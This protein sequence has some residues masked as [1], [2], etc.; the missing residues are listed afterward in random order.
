MSYGGGYGGRYVIS[1]YGRSS[2][3]PYGIKWLL[4]VNI[5]LFVAYFFAVRT[6]LGSLFHY[7]GLIP[8]AVVSLL[9]VWQLVTYLFLHDPWD[10]WH[11]LIN[12]AM[13]WMFGKDLEST[14]GTK[15]FL[16]YYFVCGIGAAI[17]VVLMNL[18]FG[19]MSSRTIGASGAIFGV[20][21]A[22]GMMFP[23]TTVLFSLIIP[24]KAKY[25]VMIMGA[26]AFLSTLGSSGGGV[27][28]IAHL[29]GMIFGYLYLK[30]KYVKLDIFGSL[31]RQYKDWKVQRAKKKF[32]VYLKKK[33]GKGPWV[34]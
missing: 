13:L 17:C 23:D 25:F 22:F 2:M 10:F 21:L 12:M 33:G 27:S 24:M 32:Q 16:Q 11:I 18:V 15:R 20:M 26:I 31:E 14:W 7:F 8:Q 19:D 1:G 9:A 30:S 3:F 4:I 6:G 29:G 28:H 34:N 5:A